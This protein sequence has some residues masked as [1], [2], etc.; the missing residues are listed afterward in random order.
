MH[1]MHHMIKNKHFISL[2]PVLYLPEKA[3]NQVKY[4]FKLYY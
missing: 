4:D 3:A 2:F 1:F